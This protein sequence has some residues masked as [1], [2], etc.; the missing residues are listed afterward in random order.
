MTDDDRYLTHA[1]RLAT[2]S[3]RSGGGPFGAVI[4]GPAGEVVEG[5]NAVVSSGDPTA[6]AEVQ[7]IRAAARVLGSHVLAGSTL[8]SSCEP[9]PMCLG[10]IHWARIDRIVFAADR[11]SAAAAGFDDAHLYEQLQLDHPERRLPTEQRLPDEGQEP[12]SAW[13]LHDDR[14]PY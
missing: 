5:A 10:A 1:I 13:E 6:H 12:F 2:E 14:T 9:C 8:Y 7:A 3:A 11:H 4:V